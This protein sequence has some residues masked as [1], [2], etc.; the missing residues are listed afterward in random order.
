M[1]AG[2]PPATIWRVASTPSRFGIRTSI[3]ITSG[4]VCRARLTA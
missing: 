2:L 3:K 4:W 1:R